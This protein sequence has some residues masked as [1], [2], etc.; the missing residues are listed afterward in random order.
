[1]SDTARQSGSCELCQS[2]SPLTKVTV[3]HAPSPTFVYLCATCQEASANPSTHVEQ[4]KTL[5]DAMW[6]EHDGVKVSA[7]RLLKSMPSESFAVDALDMLYLEDDM[8]A[9]ADLGVIDAPELTVIQRDVNGVVLS[10]GDT[11]TLIK[12]LVVKGAGFT[13]KRGTAVRG[14]GLTDN[15]EHIEDRVNGQRIVIITAYVKKS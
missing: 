3:E 1:M 15:P 10:A 5:P 12:D 6:S 13:A 8:K 14:I 9:W 4:W 11:V 7:Y 2:E